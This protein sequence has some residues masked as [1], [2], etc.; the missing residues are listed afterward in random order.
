MKKLLPLMGLLLFSIGLQAQ[1]NRTNISLQ[2]GYHGKLLNP[3]PL[4]AVI[5]SFNF[6]S[7]LNMDLESVGAVSGFFAGIGV[8]P[9]RSHFRLDAMN[10]NTMFTATG[11]DDQGV[12]QRRDLALQGARFSLGF[13]SELIRFY[14]EGH[15]CVGA[16]FNVNY[17]NI[18][19]TQKPAAEFNVDDPLDEAMTSWKPSFTIHT[20]L[21]F[22]IGPQVKVSIEPYYQIYFGPTDFSPVNEALNP[23][24]FQ[25]TPISVREGDLDHLGLNLAVIVFLLPR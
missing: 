2:A 3:R 10:Y 24:T 9:G 5:D 4:N 16:S 14:K 17:L 11:T 19:S 18:S 7:G 13:T 23:A 6:Y 8:H 12:E 25:N 1:S 22:G 20:P 15:F 21:R